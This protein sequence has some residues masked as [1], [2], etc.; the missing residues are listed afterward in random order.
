MITFFCNADLLVAI[1]SLV[2]FKDKN[3]EESILGWFGEKFGLGLC[4]NVLKLFFG[5][6]S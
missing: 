1:I 4:C 6:N 5:E 3:N 2:P